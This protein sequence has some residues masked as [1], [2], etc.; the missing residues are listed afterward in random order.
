MKVVLHVGLHRQRPGRY[1]VPEISQPFIPKPFRPMDLVK[2]VRDSL[3]A[4]RIT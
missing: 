2:K 3:D 4:S 1:G